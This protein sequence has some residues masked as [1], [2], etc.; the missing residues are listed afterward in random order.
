MRKFCFFYLLVAIFASHHCL[1]NE[2]KVKSFQPAGNLDLSARIKFK[3]DINGD[4]C[5]LVKVR[6]NE[7]G[8]TIHA[9]PDPEDQFYDSQLNELWVY[10]SKGTRRLKIVKDG[11][12]TFEYIIPSE[13]KIESQ[14]TYVLVLDAKSS[15]ARSTTDRGHFSVALKSGQARITMNDN[16]SFNEITPYNS[17]SKKA[18]WPTGEYRLLIKRD[19]YLTIDTTI[20]VKKD[21]LTAIELDMYPVFEYITFNVE[22][23]IAELF[24]MG[25][26][27]NKSN[28][29]LKEGKAELEFKAPG[30][31]TEI[32]NLEI[33]GGGGSREVAIKLNPIM[34]SI[35]VE[36][37]N[38]Q[39]KG[40]TVL[41]GDK[42]VGTIPLY[43]Y[44]LQEG[45]YSLT[46]K[47]ENFVTIKKQITIKEN[48][49]E[50]LNEAVTN[51]VN[52]AISSDPA[53]ADFKINNTITGTTPQ[54]VKVPIGNNSILLSKPKF[55]E[56]KE[57]FSINE[58][59]GPL[60]FRLKPDEFLKVKKQLRNNSLAYY[61]TMAI[62][63]GGL[64]MSGYQSF[65]YFT[66]TEKYK[67]ATTEATQLN[68]DIVKARNLAAISLGTAVVAYIPY[69]IL[70]SKR[71]TL[72]SRS[73]SFSFVPTSD[74]ML[75][76]MSLNF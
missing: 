8:I 47:K 71:K 35:T 51:L 14:K 4:T 5:A 30:F 72:K 16:P 33:K 74:G 36:A 59:S 40:A 32:T 65:S 60:S 68:A 34:G 27:M 22:P 56:A 20:V 48:S 23:A 58:N 1:A 19:D 11:Y 2:F 13:I 42:A 75:M 39:A 63:V 18:S 31:Y 26:K 54:T 6:A 69:K 17:Q 24:F 67:T 15:S 55:I 52:I 57:N 49:N 25:Q 76:A 38:E 3:I 53:G 44:P 70:K 37:G 43:T 21:E 45:E 41:I 62:V 28:L 9:T 12:T 46:I 7:K 66:M 10:I 50:I 29:K 61:P 73:R 64:A